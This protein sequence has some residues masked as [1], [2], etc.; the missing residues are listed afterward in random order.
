M[1]KTILILETIALIAS[2]IAKELRRRNRG[3]RVNG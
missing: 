1:F 3:G 2:A